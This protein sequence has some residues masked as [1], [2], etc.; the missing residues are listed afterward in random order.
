MADSFLVGVNLERLH[1]NFAMSDAKLWTVDEVKDWLREVGFVKC[2]EGWL[3]EEITL[4]SLDQR[5]ILSVR[6]L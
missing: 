3:C 1:H 5:E 2:S 6:E 4:A